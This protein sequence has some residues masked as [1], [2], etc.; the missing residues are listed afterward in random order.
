MSQ[1][2]GAYAVTTRAIANALLQEATSERVW[3]GSSAGE[4]VI[5]A[6]AFSGLVMLDRADFS[7]PAAIA[8][9]VA[10]RSQRERSSATCC[11]ATGRGP[12][13]AWR[14]SIPTSR[15]S[16]RLKQA[17]VASLLHCD[18]VPLRGEV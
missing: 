3:R 17:T 16:Q 10:F 9:F 11:D 6:A 14:S 8:W 13:S 4:T 1:E 2:I 15:R 12:F 5:V 18:I 7:W